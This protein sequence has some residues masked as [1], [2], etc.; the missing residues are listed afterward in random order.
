MLR[1]LQFIWHPLEKFNKDLINEIK[2]T[3]V[4]DG[5]CDNKY[6][7]LIQQLV[8]KSDL[9][10]MKIVFPVEV[11]RETVSKLSEEPSP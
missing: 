2:R 7:N 9:S 11:N 8:R 1:N 4:K 6:E 10:R 5:C 3:G